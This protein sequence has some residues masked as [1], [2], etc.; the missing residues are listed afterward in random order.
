MKTCVT[1]KK[2][3]PSQQIAEEALIEAQAH[4][5]YGRASGPIAVYRCEDCGEYHLTS[6]GTM[7]E[8]LVSYIKDGTLNK[9]KEANRWT[10]K[11]K[12]R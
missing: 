10:T 2:S 4:F 6:K 3:Y 8:K 9:L 12:K 5:D 7:N 11:F 1:G